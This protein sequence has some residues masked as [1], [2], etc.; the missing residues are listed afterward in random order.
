MTTLKAQRA[1]EVLA[2]RH[3]SF[4]KRVATLTGHVGESVSV[5]AMRLAFESGTSADEFAAQIAARE[6]VGR[7]LHTQKAEAI[8]AAA[9]DAAAVIGNVQLELEKAGWDI[10]AAAPYPA[11]RELYQ[12]DY[13]TKK[14]KHYLFGSLTENGLD[15]YQSSREG[16]PYIVKMR[17]EAI[18]RFIRQAEQGA[19]LQYD[20]FICK[21]VKKIGAG[22]VDAEI[23]GDHIWGYSFLTV[24]LKDGTTERWK[25]QQIWNYSVHGLRFPQWPSRKVK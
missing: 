18:D 22:A 13:K 2:N 8:K 12:P 25:T 20:M 23:T 4:A 5:R 16:Q 3:T 19:A 24:T 9:M 6:P 7:A 11:Y 15:G 10:N 21:M 14:A 17:D 1:A